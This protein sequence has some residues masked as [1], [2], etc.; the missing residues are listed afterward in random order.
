MVLAFGS[1]IDTASFNETT[2]IIA[3]SSL[4]RIIQN[5]VEREEI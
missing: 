4:A 2:D 5:N 3:S 1:L